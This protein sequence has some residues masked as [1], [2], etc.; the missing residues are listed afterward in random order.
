MINILEGD[1]NS[2]EYSEYPACVCLSAVCSA[3]V[4]PSANN[5][6]GATQQKVC[7][8]K[9]KHHN[10]GAMKGGVFCTAHILL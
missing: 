5:L 8:D 4:L 9:R 10:E 3:A 7:E 1:K 6:L 2:C